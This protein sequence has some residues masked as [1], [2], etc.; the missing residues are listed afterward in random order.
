MAQTNPSNEGSQRRYQ[1]AASTVNF[2]AIATRGIGQLY[3][4]QIAAARM[5]L[6]TQ[7]R[8][9]ATFGLPDFSD[10]FRVADDRAKRVFSS[11]TEHLLNATQQA[12]ETIAEVQHHVGRLVECQAV[13][14]SETWQHELDEFSSQAEEGLT[15]LKEIA[16][17][18]AEEAVRV[19]QTLSENAQQSMRE[20]GEEMRESLQQGRKEGKRAATT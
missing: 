18:Q 12:S 9:A 8:T 6:Q 7:A 14:V 20:G 19:A 5:L 16:R 10:L 4:M 1:P 15:Q 11:S 2:A 3:D 17:Q 13:N